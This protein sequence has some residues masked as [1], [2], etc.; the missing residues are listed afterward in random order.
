MVENPPRIEGGL[1]LLGLA[2][3]LFVG[4]L[5]WVKRVPPWHRTFRLWHFRYRVELGYCLIVASI[6]CF[7]VGQL[8]SSDGQMQPWPILGIW[9]ASMALVVTG[10][11]LLQSGAR[12]KPDSEQVAFG[13]WEL[14]GLTLLT[15]L[16]FMLRGLELGNIPHN[17]HGDEGEMGMAARD[18]MVGNFIN[19]FA[20]AWLGHPAFWFFIQAG[21]LTLFGNSITG[22]RMVSAI[23]GTLTIPALYCFA[24]PLYG[25]FIA[26]MATALMVAY[27]FHIHF[28][29]I[30][31]NNIGDPLMGLLAFAAFFHGYRTRSYFSF[32]LAGLILGVA[33]HLY[34]GSRLLPVLLVCMLVH[35][36]ILDHKRVLGLYRQLIIAGISFL[37]GFGP[38][39]S[40]FIEHPDAFF[41][42]YNVQGLFQTGI[43]EARINDGQTAN[44][45]LFEQF[46]RSIGAFTFIAESSPFYFPEMPLLDQASSVLFVLGVILAI[47][48]WKRPDSIL[49]LAWIAGT[50]VF[51]SIL[52]ADPPQS[53]RYVTTIPAI[54][55]LIAFAIDTILS[56]LRSHVGLRRH[57]QYAIGS[58]VVAVLMAWNL[59]F[60]FR[61]Y[62][63]R[64]TYGLSI[65]VSEIAYYVRD[66]P[67]E[68]YVYFFGYPYL[69]FGHGTIRFS[70][71]QKDGTDVIDPIT[72]VDQLP[73]LPAGKQPVFILLPNREEEIEV[74][75]EH[76][77]NGSLQIMR[78][79]SGDPNPLFLIYTPS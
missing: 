26:L 77:P 57:W 5:F 78:V 60:Y 63:P 46:V 22:L 12:Q 58:V 6:I 67:S 33:Q 36:L 59:N 64:D 11:F 72:S 19:P 48:R 70:A 62:T 15:L 17:I 75:K 42:R 18:V 71:P 38:L 55:L 10:A 7:V 76:Y 34:F 44:Q 68:R 13:Y 47:I 65:A 4:L 52:L 45:I 41:I 74:L 8:V 35:Q 1:F 9:A 23:L 79:R 29:R 14:I 73:P 43:F 30:G 53:P 61:Q 49:Y 32:A 39:I 28:S 25:R 21:S 20:T 24:R 3:T 66:L 40:F 2:S 51:G 56:I 31:L 69:Y 54:C 50:V 16:G 27:H 37:I